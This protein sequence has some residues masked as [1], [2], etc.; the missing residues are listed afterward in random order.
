MSVV[1]SDSVSRQGESRSEF[2]GSALCSF[3]LTSPVYPSPDLI[4]LIGPARY[5]EQLQ[6]YNKQMASYY[7][8][9]QTFCRTVSSPGASCTSPAQS[10]VCSGSSGSSPVSVGSP[11]SGSNVD[12]SSSLPGFQSGHGR[13]SK[14]SVRRLSRQ[15]RAKGVS[16]DLPGGYCYARAVRPEARE[17]VALALGSYP[18]LGD[19]LARPREEFLPLSATASLSLTVGSNGVAHVD[20][21]SSGRPL[22]ST[23]MSFNSCVSRI[24]GCSDFSFGSYGHMLRVNSSVPGPDLTDGVLT[25]ETPV[26]G[27]GDFPYARLF[28]GGGHLLGSVL[29]VPFGT[30]S[31]V[32]SVGEFNVFGMDEF[33]GYLFKCDVVGSAKPLYV[34]FNCSSDVLGLEGCVART[35]GH[36]HLS[37]QSYD[38]LRLRTELFDVAR[39]SQA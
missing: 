1:P 24:A 10:S 8:A 33:E 3:S 14:N 35:G 9:Y 37:P 11:T 32:M 26:G 5:C 12:S 18:A 30:S 39:V 38:G 4:K 27:T 15:M 25:L 34:M 28:S 23:R 21:F 6:A 17:S 19:L 2:E 22:S 29:P 7:A 31:V 20:Y 36:V 13:M 16:R